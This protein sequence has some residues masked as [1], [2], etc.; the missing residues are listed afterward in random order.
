MNVERASRRSC[1]A[2]G[3]LRW[4]GWA[5]ALSLMVG[6][7]DL[8]LQSLLSSWEAHEHGPGAGGPEVP[9]VV[10]SEPVSVTAIGDTP[11]LAIGSDGTAVA[12]WQKPAAQASARVEL[13]ELGANES[14]WRA[15]PVSGTSGGPYSTPLRVVAGDDGRFELLWHNT[16]YLYAGVYQ[17]GIGLGAG[18]RSGDRGGNPDGDGA[19][20][21]GHTWLAS[22]T[23]GQVVLSHSGDGVSWTRLFGL[24][25]DQ[26]DETNPATSGPRLLTHGS[27]HTSLF[28]AQRSGVFVST[29]ESGADPASWGEPRAI[30]DG[31]PALAGRFLAAGSSLGHALLV[32]EAAK[33]AGDAGAMSHRRLQFVQLAPDGSVD[34][35]RT[36]RLDTA[37]NVFSPALAMSPSGDALLSW[38]ES[39]AGPA[40]AAAP[41]RV[42]A[43][44]RG[45]D[46]SSWSTPVPLSSGGASGARAPAVAFDPSGSAHALWLEVGASGEAELLAARRSVS[47]GEFGATSVLSGAAPP[48]AA[49]RSPGHSDPRL[50]VDAGGRAIALWVGADGGIWS[51]TLE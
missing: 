50:A 43:A 15:I 29:F 7:G 18:Q 19:I 14:S 17:P 26:F 49:P 48:A 33:P 47:S 40:E 28:W 41:A 25:P 4:V 45:A 11:E 16:G 3:A 34:A 10:W 6:C 37:G 1:R 21:G 39:D 2:P 42:W 36:G 5:G 31:D 9:G 13:A 12:A 8:D 23:F 46:A 44:F 24:F 30:L 22:N 27:G 35:S 38:V 32:W 20:A 51:S